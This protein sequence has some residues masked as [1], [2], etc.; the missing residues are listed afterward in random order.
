MRNKLLPKTFALAITLLACVLVTLS[1][2]APGITTAQVSS[3]GMAYA[4]VNKSGCVVHKGNCQIRLDFYLESEDSRY[5]DKYLYLVDT[6]SLEYLA[7]YPGE[8]DKEG[9]PLDWEDYELWWDSLPRIW[10]NTPF[11]AHFI[12]LP[13]TFTEE[14]I[15]AQI[16]IHLGNFYQAFQDRWDAV[17]GGMRHGWA[18]ETRIK[19][20]DYSKTD[21]E[22]E[23]NARVA[24]CQDAIDVLTPFVYEP[25][26]GGDGKTFPATEIDMGAA[27]INRN[28]LWINDY[29]T[30]GVAN[31]AN[32]TGT[33][34]T[35]EVWAQLTMDGTNK[36]GTFYGSDPDYTNRDGETIGTVTQGAKRT[37]TGLDIDVTLGDYVGV[38]YSV[39]KI[40][41]SES[42]GSGVKYKSGDQFGTGQQ[43]YTV[44]FRTD[45][46]FSLY[47]TGETAGCSP[48]ISLN[49]ASWSVNSGNSVS[50][51]STY[52]TGLTYFTV[53]NDDSGGAITITIH[54]ADMT[55]GGYT[56]T[57][58][59]T[60]TP[61]NMVHGMKAGLSGESYNIT[62]KKNTPYNTLVSGLANN[63]TQDF[64]LKLYTPTVYSDGNDKSGPI[65]LT[66]ACD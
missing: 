63:A 17:Q 55:G 21:T 31:P 24:E 60:A 23:Y 37:F 49:T 43:T 39:G 5:Y 34:D 40:E 65:T 9:N 48:S 6:A 56:W 64:G 3:N 59:D 28:N 1:A 53:T 62:V 35:F 45:D 61:G 47:G 27:A 66:V 58:S 46:D 2:V 52:T 50:T 8:V 7:G 19:P 36:V 44:E 13:A 25:K 10:V 51:S 57:L 14:D 30:I 20:T 54:G 16:D 11:H 4:Q 15:K 38:Y 29:T 33:I 42:D 18:T 41:L 12:Y 26:E 32:D 22:A